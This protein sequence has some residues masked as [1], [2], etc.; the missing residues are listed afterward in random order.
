MIKVVIL[1]ATG[2]IGVQTLEVISAHPSKISVVGLAANS[3]GE[4][5]KVLARKQELIQN[6]P[7]QL[8]LDDEISALKHGV[9]GG[10]S[11][12]EDMVS[13]SE[14]DLVVVATAGVIGL[15]PTVAAIMAGKKIAL[16]SKEVLVAAGEF[17]MPLIAK[18]KVLLTPID[19]E[20]SAIFQCLRGYS[21]DQVSDLILTSSGGPFRGKK[22]ADLVDVTPEQ[23]GKHPTWPTMGGK[24]TVDSATL[25]NKA[26][27]MIEAVWLFGVSMDHVQVCVHPQSIVHSMIRLKD[28]SVLGQM[29]WPDMRM[30]IQV[31]LFHPERIEC[32]VP[33]WNAWDTPNLSFEKADEETFLSLQ[34]ARDAQKVGGTMPCVFNA[35]NEEAVAQFLDR[36]IGFLGIFDAVRSVMDQHQVELVNLDSLLATDKWARIMVREFCSR[37]QN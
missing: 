31:A 34:M 5:L 3:N 37:M 13:Q 33:V 26:L 32:P 29:G 36:K 25:M 19:S 22:S 10:I 11:A 24:I 9:N 18:N 14:V 21:M 16:A 17:V 8:A 23:A 15:R 2:S 20:H 27:E 7:I 28:G 1:G 4:K 6:S 35:A 30:P 12:L